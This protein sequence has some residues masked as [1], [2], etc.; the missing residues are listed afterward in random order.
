MDN[1]WQP[2][3]TESA[4]NQSDEIHITLHML[5][6]THLHL[7]RR[8]AAEPLGYSQLVASV[9]V[10]RYIFITVERMKS[11]LRN[12]HTSLRAH[13]QIHY[14]NSREKTA[15]AT[16]YSHHTPVVVYTFPS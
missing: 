3:K 8:N 6:P 12:T 16:R 9:I 14:L 1:G 10:Y 11:E 2:R 4:Q 15:E 13:Q 5:Y 7:S